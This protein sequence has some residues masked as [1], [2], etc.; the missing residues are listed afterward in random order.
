MLGIQSV[1]FNILNSNK[2]LV[3]PSGLK[4]VFLCD[5]IMLLQE[6]VYINR[7]RQ[8]YRITLVETIKIIL[9][10][11]WKC[12]PFLFGKEQA[13]QELKKYGYDA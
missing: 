7:I 6:F 2:E 10:L 11:Y 13:A 8:M 5:L 3:L 1:S 9:I 4:T 12:F